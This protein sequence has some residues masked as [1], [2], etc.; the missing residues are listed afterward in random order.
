MVQ[1]ARI[2]LHVHPEGLL[3]LRGQAN[4]VGRKVRGS[5]L[6]ILTATGC[7]GCQL[8]WDRAKGRKLLKKEAK[9]ESSVDEKQ[10]LFILTVLALCV[11]PTENLRCSLTQCYLPKCVFGFVPISHLIKDSHD[12]IERVQPYV[13]VSVRS[14]ICWRFTLQVHN[15]LSS[16]SNTNFFDL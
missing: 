7:W 5:C 3:K 11:T 6:L 12:F 10:L 2:G 15:I 9:K 1:L 13:L 8:K 16:A 4:T 14:C